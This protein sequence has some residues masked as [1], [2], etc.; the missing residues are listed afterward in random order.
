MSTDLL[1]EYIEAG[2]GPAIEDL[3]NSNPRLAGE[4]TSHGM[5]PL[6]LACYYNKP[7]LAK[8]FAKHLEQLSVFEV[9][10]LGL[11]DHM[12]SMIAAEEQL[13]N[14]VSD[15]GF[16]VLGIATHFAQE[17]IV[18]FL[19]S[20]LA[21]PNQSSMNGYYVFPLHTAV[22]SGFQG[23]AKMLIEG[24]AEVNV[25]QASGITPL[26]L[27]AQRGDIELIVL[28]LEY[29]ASV[30]VENEAGQTPA[31]LARER[32]HEEIAEILTI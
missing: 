27:A 12:I 5:S 21:D 10:A 16:S 29:G 2:N 1:E 17:D 3:L 28:L 7:Q 8:L 15:H 18:R 9:A 19:L 20:K 6:L 32:G 31:D 25:V 22:S 14:D 24:G 23:I 11:T 4:R 13:V 30:E 26:H